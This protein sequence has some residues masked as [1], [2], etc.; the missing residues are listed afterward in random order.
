MDVQNVF[1]VFLIGVLGSLSGLYT[2]LYILAPA[3]TCD[4]AEM[5]AFVY[6]NQ[7]AGLQDG[8]FSILSQNRESVVH[9]KSEK[10]VRTFFGTSRSEAT[11]SGFIICDEGYIVTN[12]HVVSDASGISVVLSDGTEVPAA[13]KGSDPLNDVAVIKI[14]PPHELNPVEIGDSGS[15]MQ[16]EL[17]VAIGSPFRL[18]NTV[19]LGIVSG[20]NRTLQSDGGFLIENVIQTDA[21]I[22]PGNSGGPIFDLEGNVIG[23]NTAIVSQSGGSEGIGFA[24]PINTAS[25]IYNDIVE[26]GKVR[27]PWLGVSIAEVTTSLAG[28][29]DL[30]VEE[31]V[32][33]VDFTEESPARDAGMRETISRPGDDDFLAGDIITGIDGE[34]ITDNAD[35]INVLLR[36][37][38]GTSVEVEFFRDGGYMTLE[39][40][41]GER[42]DDT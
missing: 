35:L 41:L 38:P 14:S 20:L 28:A 30:G 25:R 31:G 27:R 33:V 42:P 13:I 6:D 21:A 23:I 5:P 36:Y 32:L 24:I 19:T 9:I 17:V 7:T 26:T 2:G 39:V 18:Q 4:T 8:I 16:G 12:E 22:N 34:K 29:W 40:T 3:Q 15:I 11:G 37:S 1:M 10:Y